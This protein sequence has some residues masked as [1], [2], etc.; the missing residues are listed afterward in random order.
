MQ[1]NN[2][3]GLG[4]L[5]RSGFIGLA[6]LI[7]N[8]QF[9]IFNSLSQARLVK[10]VDAVGMT[11]SDLDRSVAFLSKVLGFEKMSEVEVHGAEYEKLLGVF[12]S[13]MRI[14]RLKLGAE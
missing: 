12:G 5:A 3:R 9:F 7:F 11:V 2:L 14:A 8:F 6:C 1:D 4:T 13:R 10:T